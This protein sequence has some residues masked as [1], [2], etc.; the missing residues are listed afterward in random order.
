MKNKICLVAKQYR[1]G[2]RLGL[3]DNK[4]SSY[5]SFWFKNVGEVKRA[6][7]AGV[8]YIHIDGGESDEM[9]TEGR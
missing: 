5:V 1:K 6:L 2:W 4:K 8:V 9:E 3:C 7:D